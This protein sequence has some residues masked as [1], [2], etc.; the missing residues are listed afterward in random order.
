MPTDKT[1]K[2][3]GE[4]EAK[5]GLIDLDSILLPEKELHTPGQAQ[6]VGAGVLLAQEQQATLKPIDSAS[7]IPPAPKPPLTTQTEVKD[8]S[9]IEPLETFQS[10][11]QKVVSGQNV[12]VVS[13]AAAEARRREEKSTQPENPEKKSEEQR[14]RLGSPVA[15]IAGGIL[16][17]AVA[18]SVT[19]YVLLSPTSIPVKVATSVPF[20]T[21]D[22]S[23]AVLIQP[24]DSPAD[25]MND[26][27]STAKSEQLAVGLIAGFT[28]MEA[29]TTDAEAPAVPLSA[30]QF[31]SA[32]APDVPN[33]LLRTLEPNFLLGVHSFNNTNQ[34]FLILSVDSYEQGFAGMLA[35]ET[36]MSQDLAPLFP[37]TSSLPAPS[38][39]AATSTQVINTGFTDNVVDNHDA[40]V[41]LDQN[42]NSI[43]LWA[44]L[45]QQTIVITT[46][47]YTLTEIISRLKASPITPVPGE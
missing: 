41:L 13:I 25:I 47:Q 6:R 42:G 16:L 8:A 20:I 27:V 39:V 21:I 40:R 35:W 1:D 44:F 32:L 12:S 14:S 10:D 37:T 30:Q 7:T 43:L 26:L 9:S 34:P 5:D 38:T 19:A 46:N 18:A 11:I 45:D 31:I 33:T 28:P 3:N 2:E 22:D 29:S 36:T 17:I 4:E 24:G 23:K 15:Y